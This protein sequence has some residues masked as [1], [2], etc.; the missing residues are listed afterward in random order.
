[1]SI[2]SLARARPT[3]EPYWTGVVRDLEAREKK[4]GPSPARMVFLVIL[5][6]NMRGQPAQA[7]ARPEN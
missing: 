2:F 5:H 3:H 1:V 4:F 7:R 6:Y